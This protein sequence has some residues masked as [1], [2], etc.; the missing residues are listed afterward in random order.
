MF[1][2]CIAY[3]ACGILA[4]GATLAAFIGNFPES[5]SRYEFFAL[6]MGI[7][8]P[9]G[10]LNAFFMTWYESG[11]PFRYGFMWMDRREKKT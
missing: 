11:T 2:F 4:Y 8:G 3:V 9:I 5:H 10:L 6:I 1:W 7:F